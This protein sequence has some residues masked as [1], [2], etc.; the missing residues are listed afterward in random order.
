MF[1]QLPEI[2][3]AAAEI[4]AN[5]PPLM[6]GAWREVDYTFQ[7]EGFRGRV[8]IRSGQGHPAS[9]PRPAQEPMRIIDVDPVIPGPSRAPQTTLPALPAPMKVSEDP[10]AL[11]GPS[12]RRRRRHKR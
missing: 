2:M 5:E 12:K 6:E 10:L 9:M 7:G 1:A 3:R 4:R 8:T 11:F